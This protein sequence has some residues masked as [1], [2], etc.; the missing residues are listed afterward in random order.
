MQRRKVV[1]NVTISR[2]ILQVYFRENA[3]IIQ[4]ARIISAGKKR[5]LDQNTEAFVF[6]R[7]MRHW[8]QEGMRR[9][10]VI[11]QEERKR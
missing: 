3:S 4:S 10:A 5:N 8:S 1:T 9:H 7:R 2:D 11:R 6:S